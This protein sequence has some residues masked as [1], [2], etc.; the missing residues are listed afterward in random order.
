M[1]VDDSFNLLKTFVSIKERVLGGPN[2]MTKTKSQT[3]TKVQCKA[4]L[5]LSLDSLG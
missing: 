3:T 2:D 4:C 5:L 1:T